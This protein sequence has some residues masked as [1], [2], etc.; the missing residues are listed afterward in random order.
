MRGRRLEES[1][2]TVLRNLQETSKIRLEV[3]RKYLKD[4]LMFAGLQ[5]IPWSLVNPTYG[6]STKLAINTIVLK[7]AEKYMQIT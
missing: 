1:C 7:D 4:L 2:N 3:S 6:L 5:E